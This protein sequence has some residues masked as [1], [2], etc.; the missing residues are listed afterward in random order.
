MQIILVAGMSAV[1]KRLEN[2]I[3]SS[4]K[5]LTF[6]KSIGLYFHQKTEKVFKQ[7]GAF[8]QSKW[9]GFSPNTL[10]TP[11]GTWRIRRYTSHESGSSFLKGYQE[12]SGMFKTDKSKKLKSG[13]VRYSSNSKLLQ[14]TGQLRKSFLTRAVSDKFIRF[15]SD[16]HYAQ[17][18]QEGKGRLPK[19]RML[20]I[21]QTDE[22][23]I[24]KK[25][26]FFEKYA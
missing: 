1:K 11:K 23:N 24:L 26:K 12:L 7:E 3:K 20:W 13:V 17:A 16:L 22:A 5:K 4:E 6:F 9:K 18:H 14:S 2:L 21:N 19:R 10:R 25:W 15:G 8:G